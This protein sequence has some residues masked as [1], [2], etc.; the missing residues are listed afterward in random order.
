MYVV[1]GRWELRIGEQAARMKESGTF[2]LFNWKEEMI[3]H[4][5]E[6]NGYESHYEST[7]HKESLKKYAKRNERQE[8]YSHYK[9][10]G[11]FQQIGFLLMFM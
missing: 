3:V 8:Q 5:Q 6:G 11:G 1:V 7:I 9:I 10:W 2:D 4:A